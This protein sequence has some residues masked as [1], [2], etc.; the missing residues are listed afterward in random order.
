V[1]LGAIK[2][3]FKLFVSICN[4]FGTYLLTPSPKWLTPLVASLPY[5]AH[6]SWKM[7]VGGMTNLGLLDEKWLE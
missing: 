5:F 4:K 2:V 1:K 7:E 6:V 3:A